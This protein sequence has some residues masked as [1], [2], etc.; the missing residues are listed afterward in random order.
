ME[1]PDQIEQRI[2][3]LEAALGI[4]GMTA[5]A[6]Q[7]IAAVLPVGTIVI[8]ATDTCGICFGTW[9]YLTKGDLFGEVGAYAWQRKA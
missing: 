7:T 3:I 6:T 9:E 5:P 4:A 1:S 2:R 8:T